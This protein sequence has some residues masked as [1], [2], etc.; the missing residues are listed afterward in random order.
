MSKNTD[1]YIHK[2]FGKLTII[3]SFVTEAP[4][5]YVY[6]NCQ[7]DC[8]ATLSIRKDVLMRKER[9][10]KVNSCGCS[11]DKRG[12]SN[13]G[14]IHNK[15]IIKHIG[16]KFNKLTIVDVIHKVNGGYNVKCIC[17]CGKETAQSYW[18]VQTGKVKSC[19]CYQK[20]QASLTG[21]T[22]GM[23]N[24]KCKYKWYFIK[25][26][27]KIY[28]RSGFEALYASYLIKSNIA[29]E[30]EPTCFVLPNS[31]RYTPDFLLLNENKYI[32]IKGS[33]KTNKSNQVENIR[34]FNNNHD[35]TV[36]FWE[37]IVKIVNLEFKT[38]STYL[39]QARKLNIRE[40]DYIANIL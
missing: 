19:G 18:D 11:H 24:Y 1:K 16:E 22:I 38:Y 9:T 30:Y 39:R 12:I 26:Q 21:S 17:D 32:E 3:S 2:K 10:N 15:K 29:F 6:F 23:N 37:D 8:G 35:I 40:E 25:N 13:L 31:K 7:C 33:F 28:C 20:E 34:I 36:L 14:K 4:Y 27:K 5:Y